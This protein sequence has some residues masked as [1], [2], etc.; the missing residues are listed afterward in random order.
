MAAMSE[1]ALSQGG[2][3]RIAALAPDAAGR[4]EAVL[5]IETMPGWKTY[6]RDPGASGMAPELDFSQSENLVLESVGF[7]VPSAIGFG[8]SA[9]IGYKEPTSLSLTFRQPLAGNRSRLVANVLVGLCDKICIPFSAQ[10][11]LDL[12]PGAQSDPATFAAVKRATASLPERPGT[13]F[14]ALSA[15]LDRDE[16]ILTLA[17][18][19]PE[20]ISPEVFL[21][22]PPGFVIGR[23]DSMTVVDGHTVLELP[24]LHKPRTGGLRGRTIIVVVKSGARAMET[25][26]VPE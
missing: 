4:V 25:T 3:M 16:N 14:K 7:P 11:T 10:Y 22:P 2:R 12:A 21:A 20:R 26:L 15:R 23:P 6:W 8:T 17:L 9:F 13:D 5:E 19:L 1:W 24:I 18:A